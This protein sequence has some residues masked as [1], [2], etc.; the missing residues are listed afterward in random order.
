MS[1]LMTL[2]LA[3]TVMAISLPAPGRFSAMTG[4]PRRCDSLSA[5]S[6]QLMSIAAPAENPMTRRIGFVG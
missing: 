6:L 5:Q 4:C 3:V 1:I 2:V